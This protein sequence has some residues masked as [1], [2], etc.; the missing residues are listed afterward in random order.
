MSAFTFHLLE[1]KHNAEL[2]GVIRSVIGE[3][4][5]PHDQPFTS[6]GDPHLDHLSEVYAKPRSSFWV[7]Q[8]GER[9]V[10]GGGGFAPLDGGDPSVCELQKMYF[11][12][13][14]RGQ[15]LGS[16]LLKVCLDQAR[17][18]GF[19]QCYLETLSSMDEAQALYARHGFQPI[20][21]SLGATG[22][23]HCD[24]YYVKDLR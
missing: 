12:R 17:H 10:Y 13:A 8:D 15:G 4:V 21:S 9:K 11:L 14:I 16:L 20:V 7:I 22:H 18:H 3:F 5:S 23:T 6:M 24:R 2:A 19:H 1:S